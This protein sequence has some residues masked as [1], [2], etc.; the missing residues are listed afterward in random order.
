[1]RYT[2]ECL[3][4]LRDRLPDYFAAV[5]NE[6]PEQGQV[7]CPDPNHPDHNPSAGMVLDERGFPRIH[8]FSCGGSWDVFALAGLRLGTNDFVQQVQDV[9]GVLGE[10]LDWDGPGAFASCDFRTNRTPLKSELETIKK[11]PIKGR[12]KKDETKPYD[13]THEV[14][15]AHKALYEPI[16]AG[17]LAYYKGRGLSDEMIERYKLGYCPGGLNECLKDKP[18]LQK[19]RHKGEYEELWKTDPLLCPL[20]ESQL[21]KSYKYLL[22]N[23]DD[24]GGYPYLWHE[25]TDRTLLIDPETGKP[26]RGGKYNKPYARF[27]KSRLF[28]D[29]YLMRET[30]PEI[31]VVCE[32]AY[33]V[34]SI[35]QVSSIKALAL[36]G[37]GPKQLEAL[38]QSNLEN[39]RKNTC[40]VAA[41]DN[42]QRGQESNSKIIDVFRRLNL[43]YITAKA[44]AGKD[45]NEMLQKDPEALKALATDIQRRAR[46]ELYGGVDGLCVTSLFEGFKNRI[47]HPYRPIPTGFPALD[48]VLNGGLRSGLIGIGAISSLGKTAFVLQIADQ[49][50]EHT[51]KGVLIFSLEMGKYELMARTVSR[52]TFL[53]CLENG[54][55]SRNAKTV[56]GVL[57]WN[58][59]GHSPQEDDALTNALARYRT[60]SDRLSIYEAQG[61]I[62]ADKVAKIA[63]QYTKRY[64]QAPVIVID[65]LQ[66]LA[67]DDVRDTEKRATD[68]NVMLLKQ[69]S[70]DLETPIVIISSFNRQNYQSKVTFESF[71]ESGGIEYST[72]ILIGLQAE[73]AGTKG[74]DVDAAKAQDPRHIEAV[75]LKNRQGKTGITLAFDYYPKFNLFQQVG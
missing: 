48:E 50:A 70:R 57:D 41:L 4:R 36:I 3:N 47:Q 67:P 10:K 1:M 73:G 60:H 38:C 51:D 39:L 63:R 27:I 11:G 17:A 19:R 29:R 61:S 46:L 56:T 13:F 14:E 71:K 9:A 49:I 18:L 74:F 7:T 30:P 22:P 55:D 25:T 62:T 34:L 53:Y 23:P 59:Y 52:E 40:F 68:K 64:G 28:N 5:W 44:D 12:E 35:E 75:I 21:T 24:K 8:C 32:G 2:N 54:L 66:L 72:D 6:D 31:I 58:S 33:D 15:A 42:D 43:C 37:I 69:L 16:G 45:F 65:Y 26:T 20:N